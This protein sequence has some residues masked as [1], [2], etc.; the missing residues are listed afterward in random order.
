M[1]ED[2]NKSEIRGKL[3]NI[4]ELATLIIKNFNY[5]VCRTNLNILTF[6]NERRETYFGGFEEGCYG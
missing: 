6:R 5:Y 2:I 1:K 4:L 3:F